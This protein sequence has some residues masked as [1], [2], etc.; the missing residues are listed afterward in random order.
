VIR[1]LAEFSVDHRLQVAGLTLAAAAL[2]LGVGLGLK[3]DALP[4]LTNN[5]VLVLTRAPGLTPEEVERY[6]TRPL[7]VSLGGAPG[8]SDERSLSRYGI[9]SVTLVFDDSVSPWLARQIVQERISTVELPDGVDRPELGPLSGGLGEIFHLTL[10]SSKRTPAELLELATVK[11]SPLLRAVPGVVEVNSWG[12]AQRTLDVVGDSAKLAARGLT[13]QALTAAVQAASGGVAAGALPTGHGQV[14]VRAQARPRT[15]SEL[16]A[17]L[18]SGTAV[19]A[20]DVAQVVEGTRVRLGAATANGRGETM[21]LMVQMLR[22]ANA[23]EVMGRLHAVMPVVRGVLPDDVRIDVVYDRSVLVEGTLRTVGKNL[24]EGGLLVVLVLLLFLGS[25]RAGLLVASVI[26]LSM[27]FATAVMRLFD[28][29]GNL[30]SLGALD[31]GLL[32]D[33]AIVLIEGLFHELEHTRTTDHG[34]FREVVRSVAGRTAR[35]VFFSVL[36]ILLVYVPVLSLSGTDGRLFRPMALTVV[37]ALVAALVLS[38]TWVPAMA[39]LVLRPSDVPLR[40]PP[41]VRLVDWVFPRLLAPGLNHRP[42]VAV[43]TAVLLLVGVALVHSR[44]VEFTPQ[45]DEGDL[46]I[47]TTRAPDISLEASVRDATH[48]EAVL[49]ARFPEV[50]QVVSRV[51]SPAVATDIMGYEQADVFVKLAPRLSWRNGGDR[52]ALVAEME[53]VLAAEAPGGEPAF[54]QPIQMRFNELL[55]GAVT[56]V[57]VSV[58]GEDLKQLRETSELVARVV[59]EV[60]GAEDVRV[61]APP[62]VPLLTVR[63]LPL[64][65]AQA[66]LTARE[67]LDAVQGARVGLDVGFTFDGPVRIPLRVRLD[68]AREAESLEHFS[69]PLASGGVVPLQRVAQVTWDTAPG[70]VNRRNGERRLVVGFNVRGADLATVVQGAQALIATRAAAPQGL[71]YEW[72]GQYENLTNASRRLALVVPVVLA[73]ILLVLAATFSR[74]KPAAVI[75]MLVPFA[76]VGGV[77]ALTARGLPIS[78]PAAIGF[79]ALSGIAVMNG[80]VWMTRA[81]ELLDEGRDVALAAKEAALVR[82][83]PVLMTALVAAFGFLPMMLAHGVGAEVQRPLATVVVGGLASSTFL[84]L[85][86]LPALFPLLE[87]RRR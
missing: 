87:R 25:W 52:E 39:S 45:L 47:Q 36:V 27:A 86:V 41:V 34:S 83:R 55:G 11:V 60:P 59:K 33:G 29:P 2:A 62:S 80:V 49:R 84:T 1:R 40:P 77:A 75:F 46:V 57:T 26:P 32:V 22:D 54:T 67:V 14:L 48:L 38:L 64:M 70:Q 56:D 73:L 51:G 5:Q 50:L 68:G 66:G 72:G 12:G 78:L 82:A 37:F 35:P 61:L 71:R 17:A 85:F 16:G 19:R 53:R 4:D 13:F 58:Y 79:I 15:P 7:E 10:S 42:A 28:V 6:V 74:L 81:L 3:L 76:C 65:T 23:L 18:V 31:F 20:A 21:Y 69:L 63:P 24:L 9:S 30:M 44:G 8:L 43:G